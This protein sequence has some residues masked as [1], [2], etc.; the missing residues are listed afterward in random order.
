MLARYVRDEGADA[1]LRDLLARVAAE[2]RA[3]AI[4]PERLLIVLK[5]VWTSLPEVRQAEHTRLGVH[6]AL[7]ER[8][9]TRCIREYYAA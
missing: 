9:I 7:L 5:E 1:E 3:K 6:N 2:A 4:L 8:L